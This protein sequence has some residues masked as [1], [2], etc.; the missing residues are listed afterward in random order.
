MEEINVKEFFNYL[1]KYI[2]VLIVFLLIAAGGIFVFD[3]TIKRP[4]YQ[5]QATV[6]I[7]RYESTDST[8]G[9]TND[10]ASSQRLASIYGEIIKSDLVLG[11]VINDLNLNMGVGEL[12]GNIT[13]KIAGDTTMLTVSAKDY[14][15]KMTAAIVNK[16]VDVAT[17]EIQGIYK[18]GSIAQLNSATAPTAPINNTL[19]RD[20]TVAGAVI[21]LG[22]L[23]FAFLKFYLDKTIKYD[24]NTEKRTG[25]SVTGIIPEANLR[26]RRA[27]YKIEKQ[28]M[29]AVSESFKILRVNLQ[30]AITSKRFK[31][32]LVT[33]TNV[34]EGKTFVA[35]NLAM[36]FAQAGKKVV[37]VDSDLR[38]G[39][40]SR[41]FD[42]P[43]EKGL[44]EYL[45][46]A[47][48]DFDKYIYATNTKNLSVMPGGKHPSNPSELLSTR[49][50]R[51]LVKMLSEVYD[52]VVF[53]SAPVNGYA[54][55]IIMASYADETLLVVR[56][57]VTDI[58]D[59]ES[60][61][62]SLKKVGAKITGVVMNR[63]DTDLK[64]K[65]N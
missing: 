65:V 54:D 43:N 40:L 1:K 58:D 63:V 33:S 50:S 14:D 47:G 11:K 42:I 48:H 29:I 21:V 7:T 61:K 57:G 22:V 28:P 56:N 62:N 49:R 6:I 16:A 10:I 31:T 25:L 3:K 41:L 52:I 19:S 53:D 23:G 59:F 46:G 35:A 24:E 9:T 26:A 44:A 27:D 38:S 34:G 15:A 8:S 64:Y 30:F 45:A 60:A 18:I 32:L 2:A 17:E 36:S 4:V 5:A 13:T 39:N 37:L 12:R 51:D 20:L 55:S